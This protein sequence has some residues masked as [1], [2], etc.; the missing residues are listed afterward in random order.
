[1]CGREVG[2]LIR[3][4]KRRRSGSPGGGGG[5]GRGG[6]EG[7]EKAPGAGAALLPAG[8]QSSPVV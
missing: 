3:V 6:P 5:G 4:E 2:G 8:F 7:A 1:M